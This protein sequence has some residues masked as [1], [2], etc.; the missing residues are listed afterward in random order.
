MPS[1]PPERIQLPAIAGRLLEA[2]ST[3]AVYPRRF[4]PIAASRHAP[5]VADG[6]VQEGTRR[7][8]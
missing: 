5:S 6:G 8:I 4:V 2:D 1:M 7:R 3:T